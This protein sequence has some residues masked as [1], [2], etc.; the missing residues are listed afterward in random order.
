M[1]EANYH[2]L[3]GWFCFFR[4][5]ETKE[6]RKCCCF[7]L[8]SRAKH[9]VSKQT[10]KSLS[11]FTPLGRYNINLQLKIHPSDMKYLTGLVAV[12]RL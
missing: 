9:G 1:G 6:A 10:I 2:L 8:R 5:D 7:L 4:K 3:N 12:V 11:I